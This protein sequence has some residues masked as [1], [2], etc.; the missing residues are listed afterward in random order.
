MHRAHSRPLAA[1][2]RHRSRDHSYREETPRGL[3]EGD[4]PTEVMEFQTLRYD[5]KKP[6]KENMVQPTVGHIQQLRKIGY[7]N[8]IRC[9]CSKRFL[10]KIRNRVLMPDSSLRDF[11]RAVREYK[12]KRKRKQAFALRTRQRV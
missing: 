4:E 11:E 12:S 1:N 10:L 2:A 8:L 3:E 9:G 7:P 6:A 5:R